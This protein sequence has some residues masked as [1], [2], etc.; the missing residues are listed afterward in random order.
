[1]K[2]NGASEWI[3]RSPAGRAAGGGYEEKKKPVLAFC[4]IMLSIGLVVAVLLRGKLP[5]VA[6][7]RG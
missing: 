5:Q 2:H 6:S 4:S 3:S 1:M 7:R